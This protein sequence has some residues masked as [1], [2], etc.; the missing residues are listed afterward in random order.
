VNSPNLKAGSA[1]GAYRLRR[2]IARSRW[3]SVYSAES[4]LL[5]GK[6]AVKIFDLNGSN[7]DSIGTP[8]ELVWRNRF[9]LEARILGAM[10]HPGITAL[11]DKGC[12]SDGRPYH[13]MPFINANLAY[14]IKFEVNES[15][16]QKRR[17][18]PKRK[19]VM[20][21]E[22]S[23]S[24]LSQIV[25]ALAA[26]HKCGIIHR[27]LKPGNVLLSRIGNGHAVLCDFGM[28]RW[29]DQVFD[30][31]D[32]LIGSKSY[33]CPE[34]KRDPSTSGA[35][36][37]IYSFGLMAFRM[38]AG[39]LPVDGE[40][41]ILGVKQGISTEMDRL[42]AACIEANPANRP[43]DAIALQSALRSL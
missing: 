17:Q 29:G 8:D 30:V 12:L 21:V 26:L 42:F 11:Q 28:A 13:V 37:D 34:Q 32:E 7:E 38:L 31:P 27:D 20:P 35:Q 33:V 40:A 9:Y 16:W 1:I 39:R 14:E 23:L 5:P 15:G 2:R 18:P 36:A 22:R 24:L 25:D 43:G 6:F 10:D 4:T 19:G 3:T 41:S